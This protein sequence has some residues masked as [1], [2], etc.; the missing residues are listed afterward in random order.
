MEPL[1]PHSQ[2]DR[3]PALQRLA[4]DIPC[5]EEQ[6][7]VERELDPDRGDP[8]GRMPEA[9]YDLGRYP[10]IG[11]AVQ[12]RMA[13]RVV[14]QPQAQAGREHVRLLEVDDL[15]GEADA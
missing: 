12:R 4:V 3:G 6:R 2:P 7:V 13:Q 9:L 10:E 15:Q 1:V 8:P 5:P 11:N 14:G